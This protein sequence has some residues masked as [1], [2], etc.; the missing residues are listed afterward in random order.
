[1]RTRHDALKCATRFDTRSIQ[2]LSKVV[3]RATAMPIQ[4]NKAIVG[5]NA[6]FS[7]ESGIHQDVCQGSL[8]LRNL[9]SSA[10]EAERQRSRLGVT[11]DGGAL[12]LAS[13]NSFLASTGEREQLERL[14]NTLAQTRRVVRDLDVLEDWLSRLDADQIGVDRHDP[15]LF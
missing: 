3:A 7:H 6:C 8:Y 1:M 13:K 15:D 9:E 12:L 10:R 11:P 14:F 2:R 4:K 5:R